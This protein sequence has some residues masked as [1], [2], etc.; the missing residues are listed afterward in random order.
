MRGCSA[1]FNSINEAGFMH[2]IVFTLHVWNL[3][4]FND[5]VNLFD[6]FLSAH[7]TPVFQI[8]CMVS[9][10]EWWV[11]LP[12]WKHFLHIS[13][14]G[15]L[16]ILSKRHKIMRLKTFWSEYIPKMTWFM[17]SNSLISFHKSSVWY[18]K[19][20]RKCLSLGIILL[21]YITR[22]QINV[23]YFMSVPPWS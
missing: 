7:D 14:H 3:F 22:T 1:L 11:K 16:S 13:C 4:L 18:L 9:K 17:R 12:Q 15:H 6:S 5:L 23:I 20:P 10:T 21:K 8:P 2:G 19:P